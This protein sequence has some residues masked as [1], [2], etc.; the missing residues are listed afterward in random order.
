M[1]AICVEIETVMN[2]PELILDYAAEYMTI[3]SYV[4]LSNT[5]LSMLN[6]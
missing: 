1:C 4:M 5:S 2:L 3:I 6:T